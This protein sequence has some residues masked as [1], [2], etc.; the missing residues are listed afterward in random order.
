M[1]IYRAEE[2]PL[3]AVGEMVGDYRV[4]NI[5]PARAGGLLLLVDKQPIKN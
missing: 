4:A 1:V 3:A 5:Y 2:W